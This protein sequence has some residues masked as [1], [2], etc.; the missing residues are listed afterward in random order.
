MRLSHYAL[1]SGKTY[2]TTTWKLNLDASPIDGLHL[3]GSIN[4]AARVPD[5]QQ[6]YAGQYVGPDG[7]SDPCAGIVIT[8]ANTGCLAQG[9][10]VGQYVVANPAGQ[11]NGLRGGTASLHPEIATT[12]TLGVVLAPSLIPAFSLSVDWF[13]IKVRNAIESFGANA[14]M[15]A[16]M[17]G[18]TTACGLIHRDPGGSLW[19]TPGGYVA[20]LPTNIGAVETSGF[21]FN[22]AYA[23]RLGRIGTLSLDL[24]GTLLDKA[25]TSNGLSAPYDCAGYYGPTCGTPAPHWR[26]QA[27]AT[28]SGPSRWTASLQWRYI[29]PVVIEYLNPSATLAGN[30]FTFGSRIPGQSY[31]DLALSK[32]LGRHLLLRAGVNNLFD[33]DPP[34]F[35]SGAADYGASGCAPVVCNGNTYPGTYDALGRYIYT[36]LSLDF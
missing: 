19:L 36:A 27:R 17:G 12:K 35:A 2:N 15:T 22:A 5:I 14:I 28:L 29:G 13:D 4:R 3:R 7:A 16:C 10:S 33:K 32:G 18:N 31:F 20:D 1:T 24:V 34:L 23:R 6:L 9:L 30:A 21:D 8:A 26:H 11:Y 25:R